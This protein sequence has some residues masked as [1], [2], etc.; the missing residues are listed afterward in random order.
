MHFWQS[1]NEF[2]SSWFNLTVPKTVFDSTC[3]AAG[4]Y[5]FL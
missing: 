1:R 4:V 5:V 2:Q 3:L